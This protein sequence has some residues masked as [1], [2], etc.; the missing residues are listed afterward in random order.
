M[1]QIQIYSLKI[2]RKLYSKIFRE[3][4]LPALDRLEDPNSISD[5]IYSFLISDKPC[6]ISRFGSTELSA[7]V[8]YLGVINKKHSIVNYIKGKEPE[9]WWNKNIMY[10]MQ[11]WSGFY[12]PTSSNILKFGDLMIEDA[13]Q[14]DILGC[15]LLNENYIY[16]YCNSNL[17]KVWLIFLDPFWV[18]N[19]WTRA[20][21]GKNVLVIHPFAEIIEE[22]YRSNRERLFKNQNILPEFKLKTIKAVQ[23][24]GGENNEFES[25]FEA[26]NSMKRK[27]DET[28]FD[29]CLLG[30]GAYGF[31]LAAHIKRIGKKAVHLGGSLQLLFGIIGSRWENPDYA[32]A[33]RKVCPDLS[34]PSLFNH[35]W[36]RPT[37]LRNE[38]TKK[39]ENNC[40]W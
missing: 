18:K 13:K 19:P 36:V 23:S 35:Y 6:M 20:L 24:L 38:K 34:Y 16:K 15:W 2:L 27:I 29:I 11:N 33:A 9:W 25:W 40:Y 32:K 8:N 4:K 28:D 7:V 17:K 3:Y 1:N 12:P 31:P 14:V 22:Q 5:L 37:H 26:L 30:C 39:V 10:Q 21:E